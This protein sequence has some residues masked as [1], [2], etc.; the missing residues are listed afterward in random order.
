MNFFHRYKEQEKDL[1]KPKIVHAVK[2]KP[3][4]YWGYCADDTFHI[5]CN[6]ASVYVY[7]QEYHL[8]AQFKDIPYAYRA[9]FVP[10]TNKLAVKSTAGYLAIYDLDS[11]SLLNKIKVSRIGSQDEGFAFTMDGKYIY[12]I[13]KPLYSTFTQITVYN[14]KDF[15]AVK[16]LFRN[17]KI[18]LKALEFDAENN[19]YVLGFVRNDEAVYDYGFVGELN[20]KGIC[21]I[22]KLEKKEF[23]Y[24]R[25]FKRW[26]DYGFTEKEK[27]N[28][29]ALRDKESILYVSLKDLCNRP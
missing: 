20:E 16:T 15:Q 8:L 6:G 10:H 11:L 4:K 28:S 3:A 9:K 5:G 18:S 13:E 25:D 19:C 21:N 29:F 12:N 17:K 24:I 23:D 1:Q 7:D 22:R 14:T 27:E 26:E 2:T